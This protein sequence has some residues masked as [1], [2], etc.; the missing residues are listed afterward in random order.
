MKRKN[1]LGLLGASIVGVFIKS[2]PKGSAEIPYDRAFNSQ[3][4]MEWPG[5]RYI[6]DE[7]VVL[8]PKRSG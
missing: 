2:E 5:P 3:N 4:Y 8:P 1:F 6:A 7:I